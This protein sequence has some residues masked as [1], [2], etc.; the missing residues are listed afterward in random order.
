MA[1]KK[2]LG[3]CIVGCALA[4]AALAGPISTTPYFESEPNNTVPSANVVGAFAVPGGAFLADGHIGNGDVDWYTF[5]VP[6]SVSHLVAAVY[7]LPDSLTADSTMQLWDVGAGIEKAWDDD[8]N[9]GFMSSFEADLTHAGFYAIAVSG[10]SDGTL[11]STPMDGL[12]DS[13]GTPHTQNY[14]YKLIVGVNTTPEPA[15]MSLIGLGALALFR[16]RR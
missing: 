5:F 13:S 15:T 3:V 7:G 4:S 14:D 8:N 6:G 1:M 10:Y 9:I 12:N 11:F 16:R 2:L